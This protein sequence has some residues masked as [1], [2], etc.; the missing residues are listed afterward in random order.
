MIT[1][2][3]AFLDFEPSHHAEGVAFWSAVTG[4]QLSPPR[5]PYDEWASLLPPDGDAVLR[6]Q[7][8]GEG[9]DRVHVDLHTADR[10]ELVAR[11]VSLGAT[12]VAVPDHTILTSPGGLVFCIVSAGESVR[13]LPTDWGGHQS[14]VDQVSIDIPA[15]Q[16]ARECA[17]W[18]ELTGWELAQSAV[19]P[20][21]WALVRPAGIPVRLLLQRLESHQ[22][23]ITAHLDIACTNVAR[24]VERHLTLGAR[25]LAEMPWWTS[26]QSPTGGPYCLTSRNPTTGT[27]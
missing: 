1:W 3:S 12:V 6:V 20:E 15:A 9:P 18:S 5:G 17:F 26:M 25:M 10:E 8:L 14:L 13:P 19:R 2:V 23:T 11:A 22:E 4:Y 21:F 7:R 16:F 24:E 27:L